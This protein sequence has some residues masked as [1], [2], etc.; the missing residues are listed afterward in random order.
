MP[1]SR[2]PPRRSRVLCSAA[3]KNPAEPELERESTAAGF[4]RARKRTDE[5]PLDGDA[6]TLRWTRTPARGPAPAPT[7]RPPPKGRRLSVCEEKKHKKEERNSAVPGSTAARLRARDGQSCR[8]RLRCLL[9]RRALLG[10]SPP[11][12]RKER[13]GERERRE[14]RLGGSRPWRGGRTGRRGGKMPPAAAPDPSWVTRNGKM[15]RVLGVSTGA[16]RFWSAEMAGRPSDRNPTTSGT[17]AA[18]GPGCGP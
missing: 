1:H 18:R 14:R 5:E 11:L 16:C 8:R 12:E 13:G 9:P 15:V 4:A 7:S 3:K 17:W 2:R 6:P 10:P